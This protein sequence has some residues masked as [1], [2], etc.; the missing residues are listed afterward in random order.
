MALRFTLRQNKIKSNKGYKKWYA[1]TLRSGELSMDDI[2]R[3][4]QERCTVTRADVRAVITALQEVVGAG[5]KDGYVVNL[6]ELG[7]FYLSIR[8]ESVDNP[9]DF[10]VQHHVKD[11]VCKYMPEGHRVSA[12]DRRIVRP[13][14]SDCRLEQVSL[15]DESGH[16]AKRIRRGGWVRRQ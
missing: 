11:I 3:R 8:S 16:V 12:I 15:Y 6:G 13:F 10:S 2:E 9:D 14:T 5:L 7:K 4:I 1:H